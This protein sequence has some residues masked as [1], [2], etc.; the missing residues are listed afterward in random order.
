MYKQNIFTNEDIKALFLHMF[1]AFVV[2]SCMGQVYAW[3]AYG[4][5]KIGFFLLSALCF[6]WMAGV[7]IW[8]FARQQKRVEDAICQIERFLSG[9]QEAR[10][11]CESEGSLYRLFHEINTLATTLGSHAEQEE[12]RK[13]FLKTT[14]SDISHQLK[15]PLAAL[16]IYN[17]LLQEGGAEEE[18]VQEFALKSEKEIERIEVL[19]QNLLKITKLDAGTIVMERRNERLEEMMDEIRQRFET[20]MEM[21]GKLLLLSGPPEA[22][23]YCDRSWML[24]AVGNLVKNAMDHTCAGKRIEI[25]WKVLPTITQIIIRDDGTGILQEDIHHIFKRFYRSRSSKDTR[26]IGLGLPLAKAIAEAH[27][28]T[29]T[30]DSEFGSGST[31][32]MSFPNLTKL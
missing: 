27:D 28:G 13:E 23:L 7:C 2:L 5:I 8:Y 29:V 3:M 10:I 32:V 21:E 24:E 31:F 9:D 16:T 15:T 18:R 25:H 6:L 4:T 26:G 17:D 14:I 19:V 22:D 11:P 30:A 1:I 20:Q 12:K